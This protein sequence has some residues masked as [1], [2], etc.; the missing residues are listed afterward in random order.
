ML[1][2]LT[3]YENYNHLPKR[4][5]CST[6]LSFMARAQVLTKCTTVTTRGQ[7]IFSATSQS[8][9][10]MYVAL[11]LRAGRPSVRNTGGF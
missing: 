4:M 7:R 6:V 2:F 3:P 10:R 11:M 9:I 8:H 1:F 5:V